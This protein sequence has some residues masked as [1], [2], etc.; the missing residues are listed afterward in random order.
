MYRFSKRGLISL[1]VVLSLILSLLPISGYADGFSDI[2]GHWAYQSIANFVSKG[3]VKGYN[4]GTFRPDNPV[5]R[6]EF[7]TLVNKV[8]PTKEEISEEREKALKFADISA[9]D[10]YY[11]DVILARVSEYISGYPDNTFRAESLI[12]RQ[13]ATTVLYNV[14][15]KNK[16]DIVLSESPVGF[17]DFDL[18]PSWSKASVSTLVNNNIVKGFP[19][20]TF[21]GSNPMTRAETVVLLEKINSMLKEIPNYPGEEVNTP[22]VTSSPEVTSTPTPTATATPTIAKEEGG[23]GA[24]KPQSTPKPV[25]TSTPKAT[26]TQ[27]LTDGGIIFGEVSYQPDINLITVFTSLDN[28]YEGQTVQYAVYSEV[29]G[30]SDNYKTIEIPGDEIYIGQL[31]QPMFD[32]AYS[33]EKVD[34]V[35]DYTVKVISRGVEFIKHFTL[36]DLLD[37]Y[38]EHNQYAGLDYYNIYAWCEEDK[39]FEDGRNLVRISWESIYDSDTLYG[40]V[41]ETRDGSSIIAYDLEDMSFEDYDVSIGETYIYKVYVVSGANFEYSNGV[42]VVFDPDTDGDGLTYSQEKEIGTDPFTTDSDNDGI[43]DFD[44]MFYLSTNPM[45]VDSDG[46]G[47]NDAD[48]V[49]VYGTNPVE[50]DTDGDGLSD[51]DEINIH[52][53]DPLN[54]DTDGDGITDGYEVNVLSTDPLVKNDENEDTDGDGVLD[55]DEEF[56]GTDPGL[57]DT[58]ED[59]LSDYEEIHSYFTDPRNADT[60]GDGLKDGLELE[61]GF[62]PN[63]ADT[64]GN[65]VIDGKEEITASIPEKIIGFLNTEKNIAIPDLRITGEAGVL[66]D[67]SIEDASDRHVFIDNRAL[68]GIPIDIKTGASFKEA[69]IRFK[70]SETY[71]KTEKLEEL[72]ICWWDE[73]NGEMVPLETVVDADTNSLMAKVNH[74]SVYSVFNIKYFQIDKTDNALGEADIVFVIDTTGSMSGTINNVRNNVISF[75]DKLNKDNVKVNFALVEFKD[76]TSDGQASTKVIKNGLSNWYANS[77]IEKFKTAVGSLGAYGGGDG[78][79]TAVDGLEEARNLGFRRGVSKHII[80]ATDADYKVNNRF[81]IASM[82]E[83]IQKLIQDEIIVSVITKSGYESYYKPLYSKTEGIYANISGNFAVELDKLKEHIA[84][85]VNDGTWIYLSDLTSAIKLEKDPLLGDWTVDTDK[86]GIPDLKELNAY[87]KDKNYWTYYSNPALADTDND[88]INDKEDLRPKIFDSFKDIKVSPVSGSAGNTFKIT[89]YSYRKDLN[90]IVKF[91]FPDEVKEVTNYQAVMSSSDLQKSFKMDFISYDKKTKLY[92]FEK[93]IRITQPGFKEKNY[94]RC[95]QIEG[96]DPDR[97]ISYKSELV[98]VKVDNSGLILKNL[99]EGKNLSTI[100]L[101]VTLNDKV[102]ETKKLEMIVI[103]PSGTVVNSKKFTMN[104]YYNKQYTMNLD[105]SKY[106]SGYSIEVMMYEDDYKTIKIVSNRLVL[107][108]LRKD[109]ELKI[110]PANSGTYSEPF[111]IIITCDGTM[112]EIKY[113][114]TYKTDKETA[115]YPYTTSE[116]IYKDRIVI[117]KNINGSVTLTITKTSTPVKEK[118]VVTYKLAVRTAN[119]SDLYPEQLPGNTTYSQVLEAAKKWAKSQVDQCVLK[120]NSNFQKYNVKNLILSVT[121]EPKYEM[122]PYLV[123][124]IIAT[125][126]GGN[127]NDKSG[128]YWGLM[129]TPKDSTNMSDYKEQIRLGISI[130]QQKMKAIKAENDALTTASY[131]AG[132]GLIIGVNGYTPPIT[133]EQRATATFAKVFPAIPDFVRAVGWSFDAKVAEIRSYYP[134]VYYCYQYLKAA[135][136]LGDV[137]GYKG[138]ML[139]SSAGAKPVEPPVEVKT[140]FPLEYGDKEDNSKPNIIKETQLLLNKYCYDQSI[141]LDVDSDFGRRTTALVKL[142][143]SIN[144]DKVTG[145]VTEAMYNDLSKGKLSVPAP[146]KGKMYVFVDDKSNGANAYYKLVDKPKTESP[147]IYEGTGSLKTYKFKLDKAALPQVVS[148]KIKKNN[149]RYFIAISITNEAYRLGRLEVID[150]NTGDIIYGP[151]TVRCQGKIDV[152]WDTT[153]GYTPTGYYFAQ[154]NKY[155]SNGYNSGTYYL[156]YALDGNAKKI[157]KY[158]IDADG[159]EKVKSAPTRDEILIHGNSNASLQPIKSYLANSILLNTYGC[160]RMYDEHYNKAL[161]MTDADKKLFKK[162]DE[163]NYDHM[164]EL[165]K[166]IGDK[167]SIVCITEDFRDFKTADYHTY[168]KN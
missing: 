116:Q 166:L 58:D 95:F 108:S 89:A 74:F 113:T 157:M 121:K 65:G 20:N 107:S 140:A 12:T 16:I 23:N 56:Y 77:D 159:K 156:K 63:K 160:I 161:K 25:A 110:T 135:N 102:N 109:A 136:Y 165:Y 39:I 22:T 35:Y 34:G 3:Y 141:D 97:N 139:S 36:E 124:A 168:R 84:K 153:N 90:P 18:L 130:Y 106:Y 21:R 98:Y 52:N 85:N 62:D 41:K 100:R 112:P 24:S 49:N 126:S 103:S 83:E 6:A 162:L 79:E 133:K 43:S 154:D 99:D 101:K 120:E 86:D 26:P 54:T 158:Y 137:S 64:D 104:T 8:F 88:G 71:T 14:I 152:N 134:R 9:E 29:Y 94:R 60:D 37:S 123:A 127:P 81:G 146:E 78:P 2:N 44:E 38:T 50:Y 19:D 142:Y 114:L 15:I 132:E 70:I 105:V 11:R 47:L 10:W 167:S 119:P 46:D 55:S 111:D 30:T 145:K 68:V 117:D 7:S 5:T 75:A 76:I 125:E 131:N 151:V 67:I 66:S 48:E 69:E 13:E 164:K 27:P 82:E 122:D 33:F 42:K 148:D 17:T 51:W 31:G 144:G 80:L 45:E 61:L 138:S 73:E 128:G 150:L 93:S 40:I 57:A 147:F 155:G 115:G 149:V 91:Y 92:K 143:Q 32:Y 4:D 1:L 28:C 87:N 96:K 129:Q 118:P 59:G 72:V 163:E 53:T